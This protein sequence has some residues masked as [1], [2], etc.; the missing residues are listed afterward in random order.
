MKTAWTKN[1]L[2]RFLVVKGVQE[3]CVKI[4]PASEAQPHEAAQRL[5]REGPTRPVREAVKRE[6][7][8]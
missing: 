8:S 7:T 6:M 2:R 3:A 5:C 4:P 1:G